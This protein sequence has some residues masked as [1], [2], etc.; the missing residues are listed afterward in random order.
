MSEHGEC[1]TIAARFCGPPDSGNGGYSAGLLARSIAG[2][3]EVTLRAPP[4]LDVQLELTHE[5][6]GE[7][8]LKQGTTVIAEAT[9]RRFELEL[10]APVTFEEAERAQAGYP[11]FHSHPYPTCFVCGPAREPGDGLVLFPGPVAGRRVVAAPWVPAANLSQDGVHVDAPFVWAAVDCPSWFG[12]L[13]FEQPVGRTLLGRIAVD[14][15]RLPHVGERL[16]VLGWPLAVE[17]RRILCGS[18]LFDERGQ[19]LARARA[20]WVVVKQ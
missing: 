7:V 17:G 13:A 20:T 14:I 6:S 11:G 2:P 10:P 5:P 16:V 18:A 8:V 9:G 4:P 3:A 12:F 15:A 19:C 1:V